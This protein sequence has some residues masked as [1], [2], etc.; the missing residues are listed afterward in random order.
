MQRLEISVT[1]RIL[2]ILESAGAILAWAGLADLCG[3]L[4][5][6]REI[7][8]HPEPTFCKQ[9]SEFQGM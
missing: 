1:W 5:S 7:F 6:Q 2:L 8:L 9:T 3:Q 4:V